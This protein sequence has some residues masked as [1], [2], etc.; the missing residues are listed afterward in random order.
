M[1]IVY[2][3]VSNSHSFCIL[4]VKDEPKTLI[5]CS[6]SV[7]DIFGKLISLTGQKDEHFIYLIIASIISKESIIELGTFL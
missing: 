6:S 3:L 1:L 7:L 4:Q 2:L 5:A